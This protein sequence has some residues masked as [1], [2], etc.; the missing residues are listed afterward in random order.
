MGNYTCFNVECVLKPQYVPVVQDFIDNGYEW[1]GGL[2]SSIPDCIQ[3]W[4]EFLIRNSL[5]HVYY[6]DEVGRCHCKT[7]M[8]SQHDSIPGAV[9]HFHNSPPNGVPGSWGQHCEIENG[10]IW[11]F[12]GSLKNY[13]GQLEYFLSN[14]LPEFSDCVRVCDVTCDVV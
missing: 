9:V 13:S 1:S 2:E 10:D 6:D 12:A 14:V 3:K 11:K 5:A 4:H 8:P 7:Y